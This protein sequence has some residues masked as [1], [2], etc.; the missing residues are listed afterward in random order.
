MNDQ[1]KMAL[2]FVRV[3][4]KFCVI[5]MVIGVIWFGYNMVTIERTPSSIFIFLLSFVYI[6][7]YS[8]LFDKADTAQQNILSD[9]WKGV[10]VSDE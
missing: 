3:I 8:W 5:N 4:S 9:K 7:F 1:Q 10:D 2:A 6:V